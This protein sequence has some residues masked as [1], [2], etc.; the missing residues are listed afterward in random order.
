MD[1]SDY[2][3]LL[4][5]FFA[6]RSSE[7]LGVKLIH[8]SAKRPN[9]VI[10]RG[11]SESGST[12]HIR[13]YVPKKDEEVIVPFSKGWYLWQSFDEVKASID[14]VALG[15]LQEISKDTSLIE[16]I[17]QSINVLIIEN[18]VKSPRLI[19]PEVGRAVLDLIDKSHRR[20]EIRDISSDGG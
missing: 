17:L 19:S 11:L 20:D 1:M 10:Y 15:V 3:Q 8:K 14:S 4:R 7:F 9:Y 13:I 16:A 2:F 12:K 18:R 5:P 6:W